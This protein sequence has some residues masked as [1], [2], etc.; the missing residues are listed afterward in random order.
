M[1][2]RLHALQLSAAM[3][4]NRLLVLTNLI[5]VPLAIDQTNESEDENQLYIDHRQVK[6]LIFIPKNENK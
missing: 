6:W 4:I 1:I 5:D 3:G 2:P